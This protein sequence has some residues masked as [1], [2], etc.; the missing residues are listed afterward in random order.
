MEV[1]VLGLAFLLMVVGLVGVLVPVLPGLVIVW[2]VG[3][4]SILWQGADPVG[5]TVVGV[6]TVLFAAG[7]AATIVLPAR[8][9]RE[10]GATPR[11]LAAVVLGAIIGF[12]VLPVFGLL[13]GALAGLYLGEWQRLGERA[14]AGASTR[15]VLTAYGLGVLLELV[16]ATIMLG[17]WLIAVIARVL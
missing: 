9:G 1:L 5:W 13:L 2:G 3:V 4:A 6:L 12:L 10:A 11:S 16:L 7:S 8:R 15:A 14:A 17:I